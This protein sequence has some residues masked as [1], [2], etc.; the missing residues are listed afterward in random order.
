MLVFSWEQRCLSHGP[1]S[2]TWNPPKLLS[3]TTHTFILQVIITVL[4]RN[5][6]TN[7]RGAVYA[8]SDG[9]LYGS[10]NNSGRIFRFNTTALTATA[11]ASGPVTSVNDGAHW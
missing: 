1:L 9:L 10:E 7:H 2:S 8:S 3:P 11:L 5:L 4:T 6:S